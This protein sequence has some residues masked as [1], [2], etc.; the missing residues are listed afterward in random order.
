MRRGVDRATRHDD[1]GYA[2]QHYQPYGVE[3]VP[4]RYRT[5]SPAAQRKQQQTQSARS[6]GREN[7]AYQRG[8][9]LE[10]AEMMVEVG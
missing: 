4:N 6:R 2:T 10:A 5:P 7:A 8:V 3:P 1:D 9:K